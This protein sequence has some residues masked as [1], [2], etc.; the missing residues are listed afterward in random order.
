M[1][2]QATLT[3]GLQEQ[4]SWKIFPWDLLPLARQELLHLPHLH[5]QTEGTWPGDA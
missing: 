2:L 3:G 4:G 5:D 1:H